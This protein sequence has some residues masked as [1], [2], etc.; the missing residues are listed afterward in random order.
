MLAKEIQVA[1]LTEDV[2]QV[3]LIH[4]VN[5]DEIYLQIESRVE[6]L[7]HHE[8]RWNKEFQERPLKDLIVGQICFCRHGSDELWNRAR[9][10]AIKPS[11][12]DVFF[13]DHGEWKYNVPRNDCHDIPSSAIK[14]LPFQAIK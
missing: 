1:K 7:L 12:V 9:I 2:T 3:V 11:T 8:D 10:E 6:T 13:V 4:F 14:I 5:L